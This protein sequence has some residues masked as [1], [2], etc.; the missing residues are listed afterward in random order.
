M[1]K[2]RFFSIKMLNTELNQFENVSEE[3]MSQNDRVQK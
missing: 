3:D 2:T 1:H